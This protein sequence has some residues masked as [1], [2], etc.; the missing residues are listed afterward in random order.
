MNR[1]LHCVLLCLLPFAAA[2]AIDGTTVFNEVMYHPPAAADAEWIELHNQNAVNM[3]L[4]GWRITGG[5]NFTFPNGTTIAAGGHL[6]IASDPAALQASANITGVLGPWTGALDNGSE[7][8]RLENRAGREMDVFHYEDAGQFPVAADG[9][10][11]ALAKRQPGLSSD[12]PESWTSSPQVRGT[13]GEPNFPGGQ[14]LGPATT[15]SPFAATWNFNQAGADLGATWAQTTH[16]AG[17]DGWETGPGVFAF[18]TDPVALPVGTVLNNPGTNV[19]THYFE[20]SFTFTGDPVQTALQLSTLIDDGAVVYLNGFEVARMNLPGGAINAT[21]GATAGIGNA[22]VS[23]PLSLPTDRLVAGTNLLSVE[24]HQVKE[25]AAGNLQ[26]VEQGGT[27]D[28]ANNLSRASGAVAF[29][30]DV[31]PGYP[32]IHNIPNLNNGTYGNPSSWIGNSG[33][34]F[35]GIRFGATLKTVRGIAWGRDNTGTYSDRT[36]GTYTVQYTTAANPSAVTPA[37]S[38]MT[39]GSINYT[40]PSGTLFSAPSLRHRFNFAPVEA[41][42]VRLICPGGA[43]IDELELYGNAL[44]SD[45]VFGAQLVSREVFPETG[46]APIAINEV[47]GAS[48]TVWRVE[49]RN[50]GSTE[51]NLGGLVIAA[52]NFPGGYVLPAQTLAPGALLVLDETQ[53]GFRPQLG[54]RVFLYSSSR[55]GLLDAVAI[56]S[57]GRARSGGE[58]LAPTAATFGTENTFTFQTGIVINEVMYHFPP[59]PSSG[60]TPVSSNPEEW[61]ELH[62]RT[63]A[64]IDVSG[65]ALDS[66]VEFTF[67]AGT[68]VAPG[69]YLVVAK[70]AAALA[71]KWPEAAA[72]IVGNFSG[73]FSNS[74]ERIVLKEANGNPADEVRYFTGGAWPSLPDGD[75]ASLELRD[76]RA[77]N[78]NGAAW[79]A[80]EERGDT[81][82]QTVTYR[83]VSGQTFGQTRWNEL[84]I[85]MLVAGECLMDDVSV[86]LNPDGA[87]QQ[88]IQGGDFESLTTKWR[89]LGNHG[90]SAIEVDPANAGNHVLH[91]RASGQFGYNHN[92]I[93]STFVGNTPLVDGQLYEVSF[94]ARYLSGSNQLNTRGY[95]SRLARTTELALPTRIGTPGAQNSRFAA[96]LGPTMRNLAHAPVVSS[97]GQPVTI[98]VEANDPDNVASATLRYALNGSPSFA[99]VQMVAAGGR[100]TASVPGQNAGTIVQFYVEALDGT[101]ALAQLPAAGPNSRALYI[102]N[103]GRGTTLP[104]HELRVVMLPAD[105]ARLLNTF[106]RLSDGRIPGTAIY[107]RAEVFYDAGIRLQGTAAGRIRDGEGNVGYDVAFPADHL[108]RGVYDSVNIDR[109]GRAPV[110]G[111]QDEIYVKHMFNRAGVPCTSD[112]L[113]YFIDPT[114]IHTSTAI[115]AL[116]A[117]E[118]L[119]VNAQFG[120]DGTVFNFDGTYEPDTTSVFNDPESLKNPVP[121]APQLQTDFTNLGDDKEQYRAP[122]EPRAGRRNDDFRGLIAFAKTMALPDA[123]LAAEIPAHM[124]VDEWMRCAAL[125]SLCA[126]GDTYMTG[127]FAHNLRIHVPSDGRNVRA[128]PW[129]MDFIFSVAPGAPAI[130]AGGNL[131]RVIEIPANKRLYYGHLHDLCQQVF[132]SSYMLPWLA[133]YESVVGQSMTGRA[134][135]IDARRNAVLAQLPGQT[136]F[137]ISTNGGAPFSVNSSTATLE[138]TGWVNIREFRRADTGAALPAVWLTLTTWRLTVALNYGE[139]PIALQA[140]DFQGQLIDTKSITITSTLQVPKAQDFL[141]ITE[142]NYHPAAPTGAELNVS[143]D[144]DDFEFIELRNFAPATLD[145][146]GCQFTVGLDFTFPANTTLAIGES[147]LVVR[148]TAALQARYGG[149]LRIAGA[150]GPNDALSNNG[151]TI[152]LRDATGAEI[153]S[154]TYSDQPPWPAGADGLGAS[155]IAIAPHL[156]LDRNLASSWRASSTAGGNPGA[157]DASTF[158]GAPDA[159]GDFDGLS[160]F[161][162]Y[163]IGTSE[164][165][166]ASGAGSWSLAPSGADL[167]FTFTRRLTADDVVYELENSSDLAAW[168]PAASALV[169]STQD[170]AVLQETHRISPPVPGQGRF[171]VRLKVTAR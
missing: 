111:G 52:S 56:R 38:W 71:A 125:Y 148:N 163:A 99:S 92:H 31:I 110:G 65:W 35:C 33:D 11:V 167:L 55:T 133:H 6:L 115:L 104:A 66:A 63:G 18:E 158:T 151:E 61:I 68:S 36:L 155:L 74:G 79:A 37:A 147:I 54:D 143:T 41:T 137:A 157:S 152:T 78:A 101:G 122:L 131:R 140:Y 95:Y 107:R 81:A 20:R 59:N 77:D 124:D 76:P 118:Q 85:G 73:S 103:D 40:G 15:L 126:I 144:K 162:E 114:G 27:M 165:S 82:W 128:L 64:V 90:T 112:D 135:Y 96:N 9:G 67:P 154:F 44:T 146:S 87:R 80:S 105:S 10:G 19:I 159:D 156:R 62:N 84:R 57:N 25:T 153:E 113:C 29:A 47:G 21:T 13:P 160:A 70:D 8:I 164:S 30:K 58:F 32:D 100:Y 94:R 45:V 86:V 116:G 23:A 171:F 97:P 24:V 16:A 50:N 34:S 108:F 142:L 14:T 43:C 49:L 60:A 1:L 106:N 132:T 168:T 136:P 117:Y 51:V 145:I 72:L 26:L 42:G 39:V 138:G 88:L 161:L 93:E 98:S 102:V 150:Y 4:S 120:G 12:D 119:W 5:V 141:R 127:G 48:D 75:A 2:R 130:L 7:T 91:V 17:A 121:L 129:D 123:Q 149:A 89:M 53:L 166:S 22:T 28:E 134:S 3:D 170:G 69:G 139:N 46:A 109:S 83:M 169:S